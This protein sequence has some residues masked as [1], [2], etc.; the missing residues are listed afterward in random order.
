MHDEPKPGGNQAP[1]AGWVVASTISWSLAGPV[2][3]GA[4]LDWQFGWS[5][6]ATVV[7]VLLGMA[8]CM[9]ML[10]RLNTRTKGAPPGPPGAGP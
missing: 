3:I 6:W 2:L 7:G 5:P 8:A 10:L 1:L 9:T 4:F